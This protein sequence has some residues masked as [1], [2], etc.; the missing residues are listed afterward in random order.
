[1]RRLGGALRRWADRVDRDGAPKL[2]GWS[3]TF[4]QHL[5]AVFNQE[6]VGCPVWYRGDQDYQRA[7]DEHRIP[8]GQLDTVEWVTVGVRSDEDRVMV[9]GSADVLMDPQWSRQQRGYDE[10]PPNVHAMTPYEPRAAKIPRWAILLKCEMRT[11]VQVFGDDYPSALKEMFS[12][13]GRSG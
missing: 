1:M 5:G 11:F 13:G 7:Y 3:F 10:L 8:E 9:L 6:G 4:E 2:T 12:R